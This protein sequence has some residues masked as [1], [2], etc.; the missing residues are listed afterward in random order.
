MPS[1]LLCLAC[2]TLKMPHLTAGRYIM[3]LMSRW[4]SIPSDTMEYATTPGTEQ[5][6]V[7]LWVNPLDA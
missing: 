6:L 4:D 1:V 7:C 2:G 5:Q 3:V